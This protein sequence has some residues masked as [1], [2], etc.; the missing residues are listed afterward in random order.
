M[1]SYNEYVSK[2]LVFMF[3]NQQVTA[4]EFHPFHFRSTY[5]EREYWDGY[6]A[7]SPAV[8]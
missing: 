7:S 5:C 4:E 3:F 2:H 1:N 8:R 6:N